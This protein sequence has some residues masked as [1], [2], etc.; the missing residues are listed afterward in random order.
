MNIHYFLLCKNFIDPYR[1]STYHV[2]C[3]IKRGNWRMEH[4]D[5]RDYI[6]QYCTGEP[7]YPSRRAV[8]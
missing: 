3:N 5:S 8:L 6:C 2:V 7:I 1:S 4:V